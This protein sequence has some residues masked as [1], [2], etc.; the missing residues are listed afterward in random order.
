MVKEAQGTTDL[1]FPDNLEVGDV[2]IGITNN[3]PYELMSDGRFRNVNLPAIRGF[4]NPINPLLPLEASRFLPIATGELSDLSQDL[5]IFPKETLGLQQ[6]RMTRITNTDDLDD[7]S[8]GELYLAY[9]NADRVYRIS[10]WSDET[11]PFWS[12]ITDK[13]L[14]YGEWEL[15]AAANNVPSFNNPYSVG[16]WWDIHDLVYDT[17]A[18]ANVR[19][20]VRW[21]TSKGA[22]NS[23]PT[24]RWSIATYEE[25]LTGLPAAG[26][27]N[28]LD[29]ILTP[30]YIVGDSGNEDFPSSA[31]SSL[32]KEIVTPW[33]FLTADSRWLWFQN[34]FQ[35]GQRTGGWVLEIIDPAYPGT[36]EARNLTGLNLNPAQNKLYTSQDLSKELRQYN[37]GTAAEIDTGVL[38]YSE[39]V[40]YDPT[41]FSAPSEITPTDVFTTE[42]GRNVYMADVNDGK[43]KQWKMRTVEDLSTM[44]DY[45]PFNSWNYDALYREFATV[46]NPICCQVS[47][48]GAN[49]Y[50]L[51]DDNNMRRYSMTGRDVSTAVYEDG[52]SLAALTTAATCFC[53]SPTENSVIIAESGSIQ[54]I[55]MSTKPS[56][57][58]PLIL[59]ASKS[60]DIDV[61]TG[62]RISRDGTKI[63]I[64]DKSSIVDV[65]QKVKQF[66]Q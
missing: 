16:T 18:L 45:D 26:L 66:N 14:S 50:T 46:A 56:L 21:S 60:F 24:H 49:L 64:S 20:R 10:D 44:I 12:T 41:A 1:N 37:L 55:F 63:Y 15:S 30:H 51:E 35:A 28:Y 6:S 11:I 2:Y 5:T 59:T 39:S 61:P 19:V 48:D 22:P 3:F 36:L 38:A 25:A 23:S 13:H 9:S 43:I 58:V 8:Q 7:N 52:F 4:A 27:H 42:D 40:F 54:E 33:L 62:I 65:P 31:A 32:T 47:V 34:D 29:G 53:L 57:N 17:D